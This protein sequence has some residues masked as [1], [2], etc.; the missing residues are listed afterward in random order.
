[1]SDIEVKLTVDNTK[2]IKASTRTAIT[3]ALQEVGLQAE[4]YAK[5]K[6]PVDTGLLRSSIRSYV[7]DDGGDQT[8]VIGT[9]VEYAAYVEFGTSKTKAQPYLKPAAENHSAEYMAIIQAQ[10][11]KEVFK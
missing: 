3:H 8:A 10:L 2:L 9:N 7:E 11:L 1:M 5:R 4:G 6:C